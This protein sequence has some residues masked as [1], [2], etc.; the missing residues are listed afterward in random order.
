M[1]C[2]QICLQTQTANIQTLRAWFIHRSVLAGIRSTDP[3]WLAIMTLRFHKPSEHWRQCRAQQYR[4]HSKVDT[5]YQASRDYVLRTCSI[6]MK[7]FRSIFSDHLHHLLVA[8][9]SW[10]TWARTLKSR[11]TF[12]HSLSLISGR[13]SQNHQMDCL[14]SMQILWMKQTN[15][16]T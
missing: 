6:E 7:C 15:P 3:R 10:W 1:F 11:S 9:S 4:I 2:S 16:R 5:A 8:D 13:S 14:K 12:S